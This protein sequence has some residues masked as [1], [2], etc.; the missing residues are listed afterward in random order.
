MS[1]KK[2][3]RVIIPLVFGAV[4][5]FVLLYFYGNNNKTETLDIVQLEDS[6]EVKNISYKYGIPIDNYN[7]N[8]G[9]VKNGQTLSVLLHAYSISSRRIFNLVRASKDVFDVRKI[10]KGQSYAMFVAS[11]STHTPKYFV[12]EKDA[13]SYV[14][15][16][17]NK[18]NPNVKLE[19]NEITK[20]R[21][22]VY[23]SINS[24]LW[25]AIVANEGNPLLAID[26]SNIFGWTIDFF[27]LQSKDE[28]AII[29]DQDYVEDEPLNIFKI[30]AAVF[31]QDNHKYY[32]IPFTQDGQ[33]LYF[34]DK[35][36]SLEGAFLKAPLDYYRIS[37]RFSNNRFHPVL[38]RYRAHHGIDYAAPA[39]TPVYSIGDGKVYAKGYQPRGGGNYIK[40]RHNSIYTT[41]YM[42]LSRFARGIHIGQKVKQK[43]VIAYVGQ[44]G[45]A[46]GPHLDFRVFEN[47]RA[48]NPLTVKSQPKAPIKKE[49]LSEYNK[50]RDSLKIELNSLLKLND[51]HID[52]TAKQFVNVH[53]DTTAKQFVNVDS[54]KLNT[55][56][57]FS[58]SK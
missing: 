9:I 28:F 22:V 10:R 14:V 39:G 54:S 49:N 55:I 29:Y 18:T 56:D 27:G 12:Y 58:I 7:V 46:T 44:T 36:H 20:V 53:I 37:S 41:T 34:N 19:H 13:L 57:F 25:N 16:D 47:G 33:E 6:L 32:A 43:E 50:L 40:I 35:G 21:K 4:L 24:S 52:T 42:H 51:V 15:F 8:Y 45:L 38:K 3:Y 26:L 11:D 5:L 2:K 17:L 31:V 23:G 48:I 30:L 1:T